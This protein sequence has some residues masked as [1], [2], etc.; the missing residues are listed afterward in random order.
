MPVQ[1]AAGKRP[2]CETVMAYAGKPPIAVPIT[3]PPVAG[4]TPSSI[5]AERQNKLAFAFSDMM[6]KSKAVSMTV[7]LA[8]AD[9]PIWSATDGLTGSEK[10]HY[11]ASVGKSYTAVV[12]MQLIENNQLS[13]D[14]RLSKWVKGVPNGDLITIRMLLNHTSGLY[15][16]N[17]DQAATRNGT[18]SLTLKENIKVLKKH[19][20]LFCPGQYWRYSNTGYYFLGLIA[21]KNYALPLSQ[22]IQVQIFDK[23]DLQN[24]HALS[25]TDDVGNIAAPQPSADQTSDLRSPGAAGPIAATSDNMIA[26]W[27]ALLSGHLVKHATRDEMFAKLYPMF[28][29]G[30]FYGLGVM[31]VRLPQ[32]DGQLK[33]W[34]GH[35]G[36]M[37]GIRAFVMIDPTDHNYAAV[38]LTGE[39]PA[40][41]VAYQMLRAW[42]EAEIP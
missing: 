8:D 22:I 35:A 33:T 14:D 18:K 42:Q 15:S 32:P 30:M 20:A 31:A 2:K 38:A 21:E 6:T 9:G 26:F 11:W 17:E 29:D 28:D 23:I 19:G 13:L 24:S 16:T 10:L 34:V 36:G 7:G 1:G 27:R 5:K 41:A 40:N 3:T 4:K 39:G 12:I 25:A 37:P